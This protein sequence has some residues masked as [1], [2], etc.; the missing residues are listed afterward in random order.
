[1]QIQI[2]TGK[3]IDGDERFAAY[4]T[5]KVQTQLGRFGEWVTRIEVH[6]SDENAGKGGADDK[7]CTIEARVEGKQPTAVHHDASTVQEA[8]AGACDKLK[9]SLDRTIGKL[10]EH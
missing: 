5:E 7:R 3:N 8:V 10:K 4:V 2:N 9:H 6:L 1:M